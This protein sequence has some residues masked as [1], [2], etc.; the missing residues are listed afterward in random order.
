MLILQLTLKV[1][2]V[3]TNITRIIE[4]AKMTPPHL[5]QP[6]VDLNTLSARMPP[7][8][9]LLQALLCTDEELHKHLLAVVD[10]FTMSVRYGVKYDEQLYTPYTQ[11][12]TTEIIHTAGFFSTVTTSPK[13]NLS[14]LCC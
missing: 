1:H 13:W 7:R 2:P 6:S 9:A 8:G 14:S 11:K 12:N 3:P 4:I 5:N 10:N